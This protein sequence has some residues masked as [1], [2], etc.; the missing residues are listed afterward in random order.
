MRAMPFARSRLVSCTLLL[1]VGAA[2][3][4]RDRSTAPSGAAVAASAPQLQ[5]IGMA[6][7]FAALGGDTPKLLEAGLAGL[8]N[9]KPQV[10]AGALQNVVAAAPDHTAARWGLLRA[11]VALG[12]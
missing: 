9:H 12:R 5:P 3:C 10:A 6:D 2:G 7:P 11:L 1:F 4:K 8:R